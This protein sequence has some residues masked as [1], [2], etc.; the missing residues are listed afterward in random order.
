M[1]AAGGYRIPSCRVK[2]R[3]NIGLISVSTLG[4]AQAGCPQPRRDARCRVGRRVGCDRPPMKVRNC[5]KLRARDGLPIVGPGRL[6]EVRTGPVLRPVGHHR[7]RYRD[8]TGES[9]PY[10]R[11]GGNA[12][13]GYCTGL[14][15]QRGLCSGELNGGETAR[16]NGYRSAE[17]RGVASAAWLLEMRNLG[18]KKFGG[19]FSAEKDGFRSTLD[20]H[21]ERKGSNRFSIS[22]IDDLLLI[23]VPSERLAWSLSVLLQESRAP[24]RTRQ[25]GRWY[26]N[27]I[28]HLFRTHPRTRST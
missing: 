15:S 9:V 17:F 24:Y 2:S 5:G 12:P 11:F 20:L 27:S 14:R 16:P 13:L 7:P 19:K 23:H 26:I 4:N 3:V 28:S 1:E 21:R 18:F 22:L 8:Y 6:P 10:R 25:L